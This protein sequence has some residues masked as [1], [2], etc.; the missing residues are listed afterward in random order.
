MQTGDSIWKQLEEGNSDAQIRRVTLH[1]PLA[2][3]DASKLD[4]RQ[5]S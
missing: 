5:E 3:L 1:N 4:D 2:T